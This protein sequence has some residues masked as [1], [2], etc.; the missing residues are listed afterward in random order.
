MAF[1]QYETRELIPE[2]AAGTVAARDDPAWAGSGAASRD[3]YAFWA[4]RACGVACLRSILSTRTDGPPPRTVPLARELLDAGAYRIRADGGVDGL[5][6]APFVEYL[7]RRWGLSAEVRA[8]L[9]LDALVAEIDRGRLVVA[10]VHP[11]IRHPERASPGRGGHLV[12][13]FDRHGDEL[14]FHN[15]SG[16]TEATANAARLPVSTFARFFAGR[17]IVVDRSWPAAG[18]GEGGDGAHRGL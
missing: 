15:P 6:Y 8:P 17:G 3:E 1:S 13:V 18:D 16:R 5:V 4:R 7:D 9:D 10:S 14:V 11:A 2:F 12:L